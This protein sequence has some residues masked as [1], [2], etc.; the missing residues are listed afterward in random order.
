[1]AD[2]SHPAIMYIICN[3]NDITTF[4]QEPFLFALMYRIYNSND[5]TT[6]DV[7]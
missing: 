7:G 5:I 1:M 2:Y 4:V 3:L 6:K